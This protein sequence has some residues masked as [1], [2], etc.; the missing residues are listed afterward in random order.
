MIRVQPC[1]GHIVELPLYSSPLGSMK[2]NAVTAIGKTTV[3]KAIS[4]RSPPALL[5][6][7]SQKESLPP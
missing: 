2:K 4:E 5:P 3:R 7:F 1:R 6:A